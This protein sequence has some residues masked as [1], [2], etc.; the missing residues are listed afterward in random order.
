MGCSRRDRFVSSGDVAFRSEVNARLDG[1]QRTMR[2]CF[3]SLSTATLAGMLA[4]ATQF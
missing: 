3:V 2:Y 4:I 1:L